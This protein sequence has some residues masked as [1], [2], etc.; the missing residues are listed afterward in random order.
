MDNE[1]PPA[2]LSNGPISRAVL[3]CLDSFRRL[4]SMRKEPAAHAVLPKIRDEETRFKVWSGNIGAHKEGRSSLDYR[5][6][7]ASHLQAQVIGL[8]AELTT[9]LEDVIAIVQGEKIPWEMLDE[10]PLREEEEDGGIAETELGQI[11]TDVVEVVNCLLRLSVSIRNPAPHDRLKSSTGNKTNLRRYEVFDIQHVRSKFGSLNDTIARRLG[12]AISKRR[13]YFRYR[14]S[15][16]AKLSHGLESDLHHEELGSTVASSIPQQMKDPGVAA[17]THRMM[18]PVVDEDASSVL[19]M[20]ETSFAS[21]TGGNETLRVP[22]LPK[23]AHRGPF[24]CPFCFMMIV[25]TNTRLW[26]RHVYADLRPYVCLSDDCQTPETEFDRRR[27][28]M[29][30]ELQNHWKTYT[31]PFGCPDDSRYPSATALRGHLN[32]KHKSNMS[33]GQLDAL[34]DLSAQPL[35]T[36]DGIDCRLCGKTLFSIPT[37]GRHVG[38]HQEQ[39]SL[40]AL[41]SLAHA[42][43]DERIDGEESTGSDS[44]A[45]NEA[46]NP[47]EPIT[48]RATR[49]GATNDDDITLRVMGA[50]IVQV[51]GSS[52]EFTDGGEINIAQR[53]KVREP[54]GSHPGQVDQSQP[55]SERPRF[56]FERGPD[57]Q[58]MTARVDDVDKS[59]NIVEG[60]DRYA[61]SVYNPRVPSPHTN[62]IERSRNP[63]DQRRMKVSHVEDTDDSANF[64]KGRDRY[65]EEVSSPTKEMEIPKTGRTR[66]ERS[67]DLESRFQTDP[68]PTRTK[69][70]DKGMNAT[71]FGIVQPPA[72]RFPE[73]KTPTR[74]GVGLPKNYKAKQGISSTAEWTN[75]PRDMVSPEVL[76]VGKEIFEIRDDFVTVLRGLSMEEIHAYAAATVQLRGMFRG[77]TINSGTTLLTHPS[78]I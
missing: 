3:D 14:E 64:I 15:H 42:D 57:R 16:H 61:E 1:H 71:H 5:L 18:M 73:E 11:A 45:I 65:A 69:K 48:T 60:T 72:P 10:L 39:I 77:I 27:D 58:R 6:R 31:C 21:S 75:I 63:S 30:H 46:T 55:T 29:Q 74:E 68:T 43:G 47:R 7:D 70:P 9:L 32:N 19:N 49:T 51:A 20:S 54:G 8:L 34:I 28:W 53:K 35:K 38:R 40:F 25:A 56:I 36:E 44:E 24:E 59:G 78:Q 23:E 76:V 26:K 50:A 12:K 37:Y 66:M 2:D 33:S 41:P 4:M 67:R 22:P 17:G 62:R 52:L 13:E